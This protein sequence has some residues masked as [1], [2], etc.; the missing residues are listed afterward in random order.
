M[1]YFCVFREENDIDEQLKRPLYENVPGLEQQ[2]L[3]TMYRFN[4]ENGRDTREL[5]TRMAELGMDIEGL[6]TKSWT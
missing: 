4:V 5:E 1:L 3:L 2:S 6:K